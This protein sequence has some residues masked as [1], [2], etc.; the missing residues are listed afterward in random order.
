MI[1]KMKKNT[2]TS[3]TKEENAKE[4]KNMYENLKFLRQSK[5]W[6]INELSEISGINTKILIGIEESNDFDIQ[7]LIKLCRTYK[8][9]LC[10]IF[11][12]T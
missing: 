8:I 3:K 6:S 7:H 10:E 9:R 4:L 11:L 5:G 2:S 12:H 1:I